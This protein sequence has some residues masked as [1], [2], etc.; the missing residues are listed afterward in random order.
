MSNWF[1][2]NPTKSIISYTIIVAGVTWATS[3]FVLQDN[4]L[5]LA[6]SELESQKSLT[7]QYKSKTE[8]LQRDID[9]LRAEN[10]EYRRWLG[11]TQDAIPVIVPQITKLKEKVTSLE[12]ETARLRATSPTVPKSIQ[13]HE[14]IL[15]T[16]F[17]DDVTGLVLTVKRTTRARVALVAVRLPG[18]DGP[19]QAFIELGHQWPFKFKEKEYLLTVTH[20]SW[21][22]DSIRFRITAE[23]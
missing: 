18:E 7:E 1:E 11:Q 2:D 21:I 5:S 14:A 13:E 4:R 20:I 10:V 8:L 17:I 22:D 9:V 12:A 23:Q 3:T 16:A 6:Q 15:G 19:L